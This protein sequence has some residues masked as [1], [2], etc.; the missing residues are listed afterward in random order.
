MLADQIG[1]LGIFEEQNIQISL[2]YSTQIVFMQMEDVLEESS[3]L[4]KLREKVAHGIT[5]NSYKLLPEDKTINRREWSGIGLCLVELMVLPHVKNKVIW[6]DNRFITGHA[7][8]GNHG[9][10]LVSVVDVISA[11]LNHNMISK[12]DYFNFLLKLRETNAHFIPLTVGEVMHH[13]QQATIK[14]EIIEET[15]ALR[16]LRKYFF[17]ISVTH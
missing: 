6:V 1:L 4:K 13:L 12:R 10:H 14:N 16:I 3:R 8:F 2:P 9:N 11:M 17:S 7:G 5:K 15:D